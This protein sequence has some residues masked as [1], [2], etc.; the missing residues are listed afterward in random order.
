[1]SFIL[2]L[3]EASNDSD[4]VFHEVSY[5]L[6]L[7]RDIHIVEL[8][9]IIFLDIIEL[10]FVSELS[11]GLQHK[12]R[13]DATRANASKAARSLSLLLGGPTDPGRTIRK[14]KFYV[15]RRALIKDL[16]DHVTNAMREEKKIAFVLRGP[17]FLG[18]TTLADD[19]ADIVSEKNPDSVWRCAAREADTVPP[20]RK[21]GVYLI[22]GVAER[23]QDATGESLS[24]WLKVLA[25]KPA[26]FLLTCRTKEQFE[27]IQKSM[28]GNDIRFHT[29]DIEG[30][31][32][33]EF[34]EAIQGISHFQQTCLANRNSIYHLHQ[35]TSG[36]PGALQIISEIISGEKKLHNRM[37]LAELG[38]ES[39]IR[40]YS[41]H[42]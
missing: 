35:I 5:A 10:S 4:V 33:Q 7:R 40:D 34:S 12:Q 31:S 9:S 3:S 42:V 17:T 26:C 38:P 8:R 6:E 32:F 11:L 39:K 19:V 37:F 14:P 27:L 1:M 18:E 21:C 23:S 22:D 36:A 16:S 13:I 29:R 20:L 25:E 24:K 15:E 28:S 2:V 30:L 41:S